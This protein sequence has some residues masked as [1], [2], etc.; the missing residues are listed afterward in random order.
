MWWLMCDLLEGTLD[1]FLSYAN[2]TPLY[3]CKRKRSIASI[4]IK[5]AGINKYKQVK[6]AKSDNNL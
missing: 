4:E 6:P 3:F 1:P 2:H 5:K